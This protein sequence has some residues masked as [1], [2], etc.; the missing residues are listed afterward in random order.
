MKKI[1]LIMPS[2]AKGGV[3]RVVSIL[4]KGLSK[5]YKVYV[6]IYHDPVEYQ[7]GGELINLKTPTGSLG[8]KLK[9]IFC[10]VVKLKKLIGKISPDFI[11]SF[12]GNLQPILTFKPIIVS[13]RNNPD[14]FPLYEKLL[15]KTIYKLSNVKKIITCSSGIEKRLNNNYHLKNT[16]TI[17]NPLDFDY[18]RQKLNTTRPFAFDYI[19]AVGRLD[20]QKGFDILI[21]SFAKSAFKGMVKLVILGEG[22]ERKN[23][24]ELIIKLDLEGQVLLLGKVDDPF[25]YMKYTKFFILSSRY[26]GFGNVLLE[27]LACETPVIATACETG[28][29][30][31]IENGENGLLVPVKDENA[32]KSAMEKLFDDQKLYE[33]LKA[34]TRKSVEKFAVENIVKEWINLFEEVYN[35]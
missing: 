1:I 23:L 11:V 4:S 8:K 15:L 6:I 30:E 10:R 26:E 12:M 22:E 17:Y 24:E 32:L 14:F 3:E 7:I 13:I 21:K 28:T 2:L 29:S 34:N 31:I 18:I 25:I 19:L 16:K 27:A 33:R 9:N 35:S 20:Q 5:Y